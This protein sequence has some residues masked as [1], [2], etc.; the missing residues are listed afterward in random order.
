MQSIFQIQ[1]NYDRANHSRKS[2]IWK[3][4]EYIMNELWAKDIIK[5]ARKYLEQ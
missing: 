2:Y 4:N 1:N 5:E 3:D